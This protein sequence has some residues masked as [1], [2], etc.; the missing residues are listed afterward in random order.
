MKETMASRVRFDPGVKEEMA[1]RGMHVRGNRILQGVIAHYIYGAPK[2]GNIIDHIDGDPYNQCRSNLQELSRSEN[3][4]K[5]SFFA[6]KYR[7][8]HLRTHRKRTRYIALI[9]HNGKR[10][11]YKIG[12]DPEA[13]AM[14]VDV[15]LR[16]LNIAGMRYN[17]PLPG[18]YG[19]HHNYI[20][21]DEEKNHD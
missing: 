19:I 3:A 10:I 16:G 5:A 8:V 2:P 7:N 14:Q 9:Q 21:I 1:K 12:Y 20:P 13:L 17:F 11:F 4:L 18:E 6:K 15:V